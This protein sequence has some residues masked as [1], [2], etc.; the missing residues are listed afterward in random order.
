[1]LAALAAVGITRDKLDDF[2]PLALAIEAYRAAASASV[3]LVCDDEGHPICVH[4]TEDGAKRYADTG[5]H[6]VTDEY[7]INAP[8]ESRGYSIVT[9]LDPDDP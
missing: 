1:M 6:Y 8:G 4:S 7:P 2:D 9:D 3:W 5:Y